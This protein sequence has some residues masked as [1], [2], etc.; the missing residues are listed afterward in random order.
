MR[1][2]TADGHDAD[3]PELVRDHQL[4][5]KGVG[6]EGAGDLEASSA[7]TAAS[8]ITIVVA[9]MSTNQ[10]RTATRPG[11]AGLAPPARIR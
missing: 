10:T 11:P 4:G 5:A 2:R 3:R 6:V 1:E 7:S 9:L 8:M